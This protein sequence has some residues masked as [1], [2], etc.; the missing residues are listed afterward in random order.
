MLHYEKTY[1]EIIL[2]NAANILRNEKEGNKTFI[3]KLLLEKSGINSKKNPE[4][5][6]LAQYIDFAIDQEKNINQDIS[7][8]SGKI[9]CNIGKIIDEIRN[10]SVRL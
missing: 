9:T 10:E 4:I 8:V 5:G 1:K 2:P 6:K 7:N 3:Y